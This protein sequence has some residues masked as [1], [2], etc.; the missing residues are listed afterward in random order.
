MYKTIIFDF[1]GVLSQSDPYE[2]WLTSHGYKR[3]GQ[4]LQ[5]SHD[6]DVGDTKLSEFYSRL[7]ELSGEPVKSISN[8][9][10]DIT[11]DDSVVSVVKQLST[12]YKLGL[13]SNAPSELL[14]PLLEKHGL[15]TLFHAIV[16]SSDVK[17]RK[18]SPEIFNIVL[19][20][21]GSQPQETIFIDDLQ[22]YVDAGEENGIVGLLYTNTEKLVNDLNGAGF[23]V[24]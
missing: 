15:V 4:F 11:V 1:F 5:A 16:I 9:I 18:P 21:L 23:S 19:K 7:S 14:R 3:E 13:L 17:C 6:V 12:S 22:P 2:A 8:A 10:E 24:Q 20:E